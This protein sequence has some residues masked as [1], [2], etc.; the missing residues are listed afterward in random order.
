MSG[1]VYSNCIRAK[2][3][4]LTFDDG[5]Y[6]YHIDV[7]NILT[8]AGIKG[9]FFVNGNNWDCI[10]DSHQVKSL[11]TSYGAGHQIASH[12]WS[13]PDLTTLDEDQIH[14][15][16]TKINSKTFARC[17]CLRV[18]TP[19]LDALQKIIG[20][21][22]AMIRPPYGNYNR[23][24]Q[25]VASALGQSLVLWSFDSQDAIGA[26]PSASKQGYT[27][28]AN[29]HPSKGIISLE[30][31]TVETT[32][33]DVLPFAIKTF[34]NQGYNFVTISQCLGG[35]AYQST[36][37]PSDRDVRLTFSPHTQHTLKVIHRIRGRVDV[38]SGFPRAGTLL[39]IRR[40]ISDSRSFL[41]LFS[42]LS[43]CSAS[44]NGNEFRFLH[45]SV[46]PSTNEMMQVQRSRNR[47]PIVTSSWLNP[48]HVFL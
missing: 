34:Q 22:P 39:L 11:K 43:S 4:A 16:M 7:A 35:D 20:V 21:V 9:T 37:S 27:D 2:D 42:L 31:E 5:P 45:Q 14:E 32:V 29:R 10:Y 47:G 3:V 41:V 40:S 6:K 24:V 15:E 19:F 44:G 17:T 38:G 26:T 12:T 18:S 28:I 48:S 33:T 8:N 46:A 23:Q 13:H 25:D 30:H 36:D 1:H